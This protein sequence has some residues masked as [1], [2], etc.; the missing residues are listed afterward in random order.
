MD[1]LPILLLLF[2][3]LLANESGEFEE[4][5]IFH[6]VLPSFTLDILNFLR[7]KPK[8]SLGCIDYEKTKKRVTDRLCQKRPSL[9]SCSTPYTMASFK[10]ET[11]GHSNDN[12]LKKLARAMG[13]KRAVRDSSWWS[14][15][16]D[17]DYEY[18][19]WKKY[20]REKIRR[21]LMQ[22]S[23]IIITTMVAHILVVMER[24]HTRDTTG[25]PTTAHIGKQ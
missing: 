14:S 8:L 25:H 19:L 5:K 23:S 10:Q 20:R 12:G 11:I 13:V 16:E 1:H 15:D 24:L 9:S 6:V 4:R 22:R 2:R 3:L 17:E 18:Y 21:R 7:D